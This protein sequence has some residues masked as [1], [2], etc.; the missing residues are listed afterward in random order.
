MT[1]INIEVESLAGFQARA[2]GVARTLDTGADV[3]PQAHLSFPDMETLLTVLSPKRFAL[4]R[5]LRQSGPSSVRSLALAAGRDYKAVH[6]DVAALIEHG[7]IER[8]AKDR[9][10]VLWDHVHA[11]MQLA[12]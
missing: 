2:L 11:D 9:V 5:V 1:Q 4:L 3:T 8:E 7:L 10:A 6:G 12:A